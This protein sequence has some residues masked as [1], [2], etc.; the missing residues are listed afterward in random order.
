MVTNSYT[1]DQC[2][3]LLKIPSYADCSLDDVQ[4]ELI[5]A[6]LSGCQ[7]CCAALAHIVDSGVAPAWLPSVVNDATDAE[8]ASATLQRKAIVSTP[9]D[10]LASEDR[11]QKLRLQG[12]GGMGQVWQGW[13]TVMKRPVALKQ[14]RSDSRSVERIGRLLQEATSLARLSH[15]NIV[16]VHEVLMLREQPTLVMEFIDGPTLSGAN[17]EFV[18]NEQH[19]AKILEQLADAMIHAHQKGVIH[20]DLKPG[21]VLLYWPKQAGEKTR[22]IETAIPKL[23]DFGLAKILEGDELTRS[24]DLLGTPAYMA[25]EQTIGLSSVAEP[26]ADIY[27]L[28][29]ILYD[30][31]T[32]T[33]PHVADN[34]VSTMMLVREREPTAPRVLRPEL[35][36]DIE[37]IC[38]KCL[39]KQPK[40][41]YA[42]V[43]DLQE[44]L[45][46]LIAGR[47]IRARPIGSIRSAMRWSRRHKSVVFLA[48][49]VSILIFTL[50]IGSLWT[51]SN[52]RQLRM[53]ADDSK[54]QAEV[55][56]KRFISEAARAKSALELNRRHF[57]VALGSV[58]QLADLTYN[59]YNKPVSTLDFGRAIQ[60]AT[61]D[62][63]ATYLNTLPSPS[64]WNLDEANAVSFYVKYMTGLGSP[65]VAAPWL[66]RT[67]SI[68]EK[69]ERDVPDSP[70]KR[71]FLARH[72]FNASIRAY[73]RSEFKASASYGERAGNFV[74]V[75]PRYASFILMNSALTYIKA[76][77]PEDAV[78]AANKSVEVYRSVMEQSTL[79]PE[80][81]VN[82]LEKLKWH[83]YVAHLAGN[84]EE[85][86]KLCKEFDER[87][88]AFNMNSPHYA[89][90]QA[91]IK[92]FHSQP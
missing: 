7:S 81:P 29:A 22:D 14:L 71:E 84:K 72:Y 39:Q 47:P 16:T 68:T 46:A 9:M 13:D 80:D 92:E 10:E 18:L 59:P 90:V 23:T 21:N 57:E 78:R 87:S 36:K 2:Q 44:D 91:I 37:T 64:E 54:V 55:S 69:L 53:A 41:R 26:S 48:S 85:A 38:L 74:D 3:Y 65:D 4:A 56:E 61:A 76:D 79:M 88:S 83:R 49:V 43:N 8:N 34:P 27:G 45:R 35:S 28:G 5:E 77:C 25:P 63:Y 30:L 33:P 32:G 11:Y 19:A 86:D 66:D 12:E 51:A 60:K 24:G 89:R 20:R 42:S 17:R 70:K 6:H 62:I 67:M 31:L 82:F 52:E 73:A 58:N 40:D 15:P 50:L 75:D 1:S